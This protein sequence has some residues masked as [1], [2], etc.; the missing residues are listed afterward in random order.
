MRTILLLLSIFFAFGGFAQSAEELT[1]TAHDLE[2]EKKY[3]EAIGIY[4]RILR[5]DSSHY[6]SYVNRALL[7]DRMDKIQNAYDDFTKAIELYP[8]PPCPTTI[9]QSYFTE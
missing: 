8:I 5:K 2:N 7:F 6:H 3:E 9:G 1:K 4:S